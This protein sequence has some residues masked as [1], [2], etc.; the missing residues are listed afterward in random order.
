MRHSVAGVAWVGRLPEDGSRQGALRYLRPLKGLR[1]LIATGGKTAAGRLTDLRPLAGL[2]LQNLELYNNPPLFD[3]K[4]L[5]GMPLERLSLNQT[6]VRDLTPLQGMPLGWLSM[7][8]V[9]VED[10]TPLRNCP[11]RHLVC[12]NT[13]VHDLS[14]L[15]T[16]QLTT[17]EL[18]SSPIVSLRPLLQLPLKSLNCDY[19]P[20]RDRDVLLKMATL[21]RIN[22]RTSIDFWKDMDAEQAAFAVWVKQTSALG[23]DDQAAAVVKR[24]REHNPRLSGRAEVTVDV[25]GVVAMRFPA[26]EVVDLA[27]LRGAPK[28]KQLNANGSPTQ[29]GLLSDLTPLRGLPLEALD[30]SFPGE[31]SGTAQRHAAAHAEADQ[32]WR[33]RLVP[34]AEATAA[35]ACRRHQAGPR[36]E[37]PAR[38][39]HPRNDQRPTGCRGA[40][41]YCKGEVVKVVS[42]QLRSPLR[43]QG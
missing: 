43:Q 27:P 11:L 5:A 23:P 31:R 7:W 6:G 40:E 13:A 41:A 15:V 14:P 26:H 18:Q 30:C 10:L 33:D 3:L 17:A 24:L 42:I 8:Q 35:D 4:P 34:G 20:F 25:T 29:R 28:L 37:A 1:H 38:D 9:P 21:T 12:V 39:R 32:L 22:G 36:W 2:P 19:Q 16:T